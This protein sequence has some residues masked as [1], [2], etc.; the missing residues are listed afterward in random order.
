MIKFKDIL[1]ESLSGIDYSIIPAYV[2][3]F[4]I[5][6]KNGIKGEEVPKVTTFIQEKIGL[7]LDESLMVIM[8]MLK[9]P[10]G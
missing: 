10:N 5:L 6:F 9:T 1:N 2:K 4:K 3:I 7:S 8:I